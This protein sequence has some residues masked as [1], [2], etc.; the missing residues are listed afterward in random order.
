M[1]AEKGK[2]RTPSVSLRSE[3]TELSKTRY[4]QGSIRRLRRKKGSD[5]WVF[6]WR[7]A[8]ADGS[9]KE[10]TRVIGTVLEYRTKAAA[11]KAAEALRININS[12]TPRPSVFGMTFAELAD[13]YMAKELDV[14][15]DET[16]KS[17][18]YS[19][20]E[21]NRRYLQRWIVPRWGSVTISEMEPIVIE[22]WLRQL[23]RE[24]YRLAN[25]TRLKIRNIMSAV[26]RH[27]MRY[28]FLPRDAE[29]NPLKYVRQ[30]G[31]STKVHTI[32]TPEQTMALI[33]YLQEP[34][35][36]MVLLDAS[37]GLR[38]SELTALRWEDVDF[39][40]GVLH[41]R[42]G[43]VYAVVG[44]V[45]TDASRS[46]L[47]LAPLLLQSLLAW[48]KETPYAGPGDWIFAS[49]RMRGKKPFRGNSLVRRQL[50]IA[51]EKAGIAGAV[52]WHSFRRSVS[53]WMIE[54]NENVKVTQEPLRHANSKT[55]LDLYAKAVTPSKRWAH[56]RIVNQLLV[57]QQRLQGQQGAETVSAA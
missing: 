9:R 52:G 12:T 34:V 29:A 11:M 20:I 7:N 4:Q 43:I 25:G 54:N 16:R 50:R 6:R 41:V 28:G 32:L 2:L 53:T 51:R 47:P 22:D 49:P 23:G 35:R 38:A 45:K 3:E 8:Q 24:P 19:T 26:F 13:H 36:T 17:K 15:Q 30:S 37:T 14:D 18:A 33:G 46:Q 48:R 5:V 27:G 1:D 10:T 55:T 31:R 21:G 42:R 56:E 44:E 39:D 40:A 57:A